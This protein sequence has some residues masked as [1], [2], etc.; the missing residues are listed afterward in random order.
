MR[1]SGALAC[2][3]AMVTAGCSQ[4]AV[5]SRASAEK[6]NE[7]LAK[8]LG[9][10]AAP[11][12][13]RDSL[14]RIRTEMETRLRQTPNDATAAVPFADA[15][16]RLARVT[17]NAGLAVNA[18]RALTKV[19]AADPDRYDARRML[20]TVLLSQHRFRDALRE[21]ER[22]RQMQPRDAFPL[23]VMGDAHLEL[24]EYDQAFDAF[25]RMVAMRP[26]AA[27]YAR[28]AYARELQGDLPDA[29]RLMQMALGATSPNDPES[30]A[31]H[32]AQLGALH[33]AMGRPAEAEREYAHAEFVFPGHPMATEGLAR[34]AD[35]R[36][37]PDQA[38]ARLQPLAA[39]TPSPAMLAYMA[40]LLKRSGRSL[41][42]LR[43]E[44]LAEAAWRADV[45]EPAKLAVFLANSGAPDRVAEA[46]RIA[47]AEAAARNDIFTND[48]LAWAYF[49][50]GRL[51]E[52]AEASARATRTGSRDRSI[53]D[54][55]RQIA[56]AAR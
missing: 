28:A 26:D 22:C 10:P 12:T 25:Q 55:A 1:R 39:S 9:A 19:L 47:E 46:V 45:P 4:S 21:A 54:H 40:E 37:R 5:A 48:A 56:E 31:W 27:S 20:A 8:S 11:S 44:R 53:R 14:E 17:N 16:L 33:L 7:V 42:A 50:A 36:G 52:A 13:S 3:F 35:V 23:G 51:S 34:V 29:L 24:G 38:L 2:V 43:Y 15:L 18:E 30:L 49:K 6:P 32:H 41:D